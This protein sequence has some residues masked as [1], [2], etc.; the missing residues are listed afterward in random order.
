MFKKSKGFGSTFL[1]S[2][3]G[4]FLPVMIVSVLVFGYFNA[5]RSVTEQNAYRQRTEQIAA[6]VQ[7]QHGSLCQRRRDKAHQPV[8]AE[9]IY[10]QHNERRHQRDHERRDDGQRLGAHRRIGRGPAG[11][12][13]QREGGKRPRRRARAGRAEQRGAHEQHSQRRHGRD[14][15]QT[16]AERGLRK[17]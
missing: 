3:L 2:Y 16:Q 1:I 7:Q 15:A 9:D 8:G 5:N 12:R 6:Q 13:Q 10:Q 11:Q 4:A 17:G 14:A